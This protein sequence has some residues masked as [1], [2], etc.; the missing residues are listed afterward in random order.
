MLSFELLLGERNNC[1]R[2]SLINHIENDK[3]LRNMIYFI[4]HIKAKRKFTNTT[5]IKKNIR[6]K[7]TKHKP[8]NDSGI[9]RTEK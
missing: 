2:R 6:K 9:I 1:F 3:D 7:K 4:G 8:Q 5:E